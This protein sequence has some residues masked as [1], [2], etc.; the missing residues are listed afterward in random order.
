MTP[1]PRTTTVA[2]AVLAGW[3]LLAL[4]LSA[5]GAV[6][7]LPVPLP[8]LLIAVLVAILLLA[9]FVPARSRRWL[10]SV[11]LSWLVAFHL[12]RFVGIYFLVLYG[13]GRLPFA[14][15]VPGGV[16]DIVAAAGALYL[17]L[18]ARI[19]RVPSWQVLAWNSFGLLDILFVVATAARSALSQPGSMVEILVLPLSLLP[20]FVVPLIIFSHVVVFWRLLVR[21]DPILYRELEPHEAELLRAIDRSE[22]IEGIYRNVDGALRLEERRETV[23]AWEPAELTALVARLQALM[24]SG[25]KA[26]SAWDGSRIVGIG[27]LETSG[28]GGD[29]SVLKL[30]ILHVSA[31]HRGRGI[32]RRLTELAAERARSLGARSLYIS[33][34]PTRGTV[35]AYL[36]MGAAVLASPD[37]ALLAREP[38]DIHLGL[39]LV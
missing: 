15:A 20:T 6:Q 30:D 26:F 7:A 21:P 3:L 16:G 39:S 2:L 32:G 11:P 17:V 38:E 13:A 10:R 28:V 35:D 1:E 29:R 24:A 27:S 9:G 25:G 36:R 23:S 4:V 12:T 22:R 37:P 8:Q 14:F 18:R 33:A 34:T 31:G 5:V 19:A